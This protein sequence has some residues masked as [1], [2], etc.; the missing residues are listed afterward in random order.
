MPGEPRLDTG[1]RYSSASS[2]IISAQ[3]CQPLA[4]SPPN[5]PSA[6]AAAS[7]WNGCGSKR[8]AK[9]TTSASST[10]IGPASAVV[11]GT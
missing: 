8:R 9:S 1:D 11:P 5:G 7:T 4:I 3:V 10:R 6:A 2:R